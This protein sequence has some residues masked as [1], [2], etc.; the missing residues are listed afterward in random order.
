MDSRAERG[1][2]DPDKKYWVARGIL[3]KGRVEAQACTNAPSWSSGETRGGN[4]HSTAKNWQAIMTV[5][6]ATGE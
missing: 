6:V 1:H 5:A 4:Q 3:A 2:I